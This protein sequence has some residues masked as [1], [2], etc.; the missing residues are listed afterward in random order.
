VGGFQTVVIEREGGHF[1]L[2]QEG[3]TLLLVPAAVFERFSADAVFPPAWAA[4]APTHPVRR[5]FWN[6]DTREYLMAGLE[7]HPARTAEAFGASPYRAYL[8]GFW[9]PAP[10]LL[11]LRPYWNPEDPYAPFDDDARRESFRVQ[12]TFREILGRLQ[13]TPGWT[14]VFNAVDAY[15]DTLGVTLEGPGSDPEDVRELSL[16]PPAPVTDPA[17]RGALERLVTS[18]VGRVFPVVRG[19]ALV[20]V[21]TLELE[22]LHRAEAILDAAGLLSQ[23]GPFRP[24]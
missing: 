6:P 22:G 18:E 7:D 19:E 10:P 14:T 21:Q 12:W 13:P 16:T 1:R 15:L 8:Q 20:G 24:H 17:G 9:V 4:F 2:G 3:E 5:V 11:L 23:H